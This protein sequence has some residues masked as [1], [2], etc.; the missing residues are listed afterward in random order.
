MVFSF[1]NPL[2]LL[3]GIFL[4]ASC[5][6]DLRDIE[7][8]SKKNTGVQVDKSYG[9][10][11][12]FSDS[13]KVKGKLITPELHRYNTENPYEDMPKGLTVIFYDENQKETQ[14]ITAEHGTRR[15]K[16]M[17]IELRKNVVVTTANGDVFKSEELFYDENQEIFYSNVLVN[18]TK[19]DGT[20]IYGTRFK[21]D[22]NFVNPVIE[23]ATG[24]IPTGG[25]LPL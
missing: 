16:E 22:Q 20:N 25:E 4:L 10:E 7:K 8:I 19:L 21:S 15:G 17:L 11:I 6:N 3:C 14:R 1:K 24:K 18:I 5:E 12:I 9:V 13:A 2:L 23:Q